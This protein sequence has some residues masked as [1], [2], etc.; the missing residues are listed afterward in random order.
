MA[1][2]NLIM[3]LLPIASGLIQ[4]NLYHYGGCDVITLDA[5]FALLAI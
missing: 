2:N 3:P 5:R 4:T 1:V